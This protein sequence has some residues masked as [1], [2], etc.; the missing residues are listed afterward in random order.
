M[1]FDEKTKS[2]L[3]SDFRASTL[4]TSSHGRTEGKHSNDRFEARH[5]LAED[6][7]IDVRRG[8]HHV[9]ELAAEIRVR[10]DE[11]GML[12]GDLIGREVQGELGEEARA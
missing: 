1:T 7:E 12:A 4:R 5:L 11:P 10:D 3:D 2:A 9:A 6:A 8:E